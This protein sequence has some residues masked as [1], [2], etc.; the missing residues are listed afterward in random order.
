[1]RSRALRLRSARRECRKGSEISRQDVGLSLRRPHRKRD[2]KT[3]A[4]DSEGRSQWFLA[5][6]IAGFLR[7]VGPGAINYL[8]VRH[9]PPGLERFAVW[10]LAASLSS[11][12]FSILLAVVSLT[13]FI[14]Y[15]GLRSRLGFPLVL[16]ILFS[17]VSRLVTT[18]TSLFDMHAALDQLALLG[19]I[20][21][22]AALRPRMD[23][24]RVLGFFGV[25]VASYSIV[26]GLLMPANAVMPTPAGATSGTTKALIGDLVLTGPMSHANSL[27]IFL[28][29]TFP[30]IGLWRKTSQRLAASL[31]LIVVSVLSASRT[32]LIAIACLL[33]YYL[34]CRV[35]LD[36]RRRNMGGLVLLL[37]G[38]LVAV[39]PWVVKNPQAFSMRGTV[40]L[41]SLSA[42]KAHGSLIFGLGPY[43]DP[44]APRTFAAVGADT[45]SGHNLMVQWL[46][47]GGLFQ[48]LI[49]LVL[50]ILLA[51][52]AVRC[53]PGLRVPA[54][55]GFLVVFLIVS[56]TEFVLI[57]AVSSQLFISTVFVFA[58][59]LAAGDSHIFESLE[60]MEKRPTQSA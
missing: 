57:F 1:M 13:A 54:M 53:D 38:S 45:A 32:A 19:V 11:L 50:F 47:T 33:L 36:L 59:L 12:L 40:W 6:C 29:L 52:R 20:V 34:A 55:T 8:V 42:W 14:R 60:S 2:L 58:T 51:Q 56:I 27:G 46:V 37:T 5:L 23:D 35:L 17:F 21:A 24:L 49:G 43:W 4:E 30:F 3:A 22:L 44:D 39:I 26:F 7:S 28:A 25:V 41:G 31:L 15:D 18:S 10:T 16:L 48:C 9:S